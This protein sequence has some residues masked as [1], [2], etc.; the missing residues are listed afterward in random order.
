MV[1]ESVVDAGGG[2]VGVCDDGF[3]AL[4]VPIMA[5]TRCNASAARG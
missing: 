4:D 5:S 3:V 1:C 2:S